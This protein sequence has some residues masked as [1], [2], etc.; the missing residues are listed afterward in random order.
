MAVF[1]DIV[2]PDPAE[3]VM[4]NVLIEKLADIVW[5]AV[6]LV[7]VYVD[8]APTEEPSTDTSETE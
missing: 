8:T 7:N 1:G 3:G 5:F 2:P 6:T 4:V